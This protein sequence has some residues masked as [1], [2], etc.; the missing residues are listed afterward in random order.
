MLS[1]LLLIYPFLLSALKQ[2]QLLTFI[3]KISEQIVRNMANLLK[4][5][6]FKIC[7]KTTDHLGLG[8]F[9]CTFNEEN[10]AYQDTVYTA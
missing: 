9:Y 8:I 5:K 3:K 4:V 6:R 2:Y 7:P 10:K 1:N